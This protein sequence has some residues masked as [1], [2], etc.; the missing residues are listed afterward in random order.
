MFLLGVAGCKKVAG[1]CKLTKREEALLVK[2]IELNKG[3]IVKYWNKEI[4]T[5]S[6]Y[7]ALKKV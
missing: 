4:D 3:T 6:L 1:D 5:G 7:N 2:W